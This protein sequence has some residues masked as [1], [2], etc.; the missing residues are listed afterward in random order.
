MKL[1]QDPASPGAD[2]RQ[3]EMVLVEQAA[4][5]LR[6]DRGRSGSEDL[7]SIKAQLACLA[8]GR[9]QIVPKYERPTAGGFDQTDGHAGS[10][11]HGAQSYKQ[12]QYS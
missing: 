1:M 8:T 11:T 4:K 5:L 10:D 6:I 9:S 3:L 2:G 12:L 7:H